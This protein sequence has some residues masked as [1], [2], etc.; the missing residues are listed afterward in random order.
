MVEKTTT[1]STPSAP[2]SALKIDLDDNWT[3]T[4]QLMA[5]APRPTAISRST[6][7]SASS[8]SAVLSREGPT[9]MGPGGHDHRGQAVANLDSSYAGAYMQRWIDTRSDYSDY[10]FFYDT[11]F[12]YG[13]YTDDDAGN[14][15]NTSQYIQ[16]KDYF[17][18][19]ATSSALAPR[20]E[21]FPVVVGGV[22]QHKAD[23]NIQQRYKI[24][25]LA[26]SWRCRAGRTPSG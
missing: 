20:G 5:S 26:S 18:K 25:S 13:A 17:T 15:I 23:H 10:S 9:T 2:A 4:P 12:G 22:L 16:G 11:L 3:I 24:D 6:R 14:F 21:P 8:K 19:Q 7:L 1:R